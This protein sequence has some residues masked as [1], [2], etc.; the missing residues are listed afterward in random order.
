LQDID[1]SEENKT[2]GGK[3]KTIS[4][5]YNGKRYTFIFEQRPGYDSTPF[6]KIVLKSGGETVLSLSV[7]PLE[8]TYAEYDDWKPGA[9][10]G[11]RIG[12]WVTDV[13]ELHE[14]ILAEREKSYRDVM[15]KLT[16][17]QAKNLPD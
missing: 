13:V 15:A 2:H 9:V 12:E 14:K 8:G 11:L 7:H 3:I 4:F 16:R 6:G 17:D 5:S 1:A 10:D